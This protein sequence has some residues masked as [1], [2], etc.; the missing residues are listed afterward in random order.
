MWN[1]AKYA[2]YNDAI[3]IAS[4]TNHAIGREIQWPS[5]EKLPFWL[6]INLNCKV[7]LRLLM[8]HLSQ[9]GNHGIMN[10]IKLV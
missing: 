1:W 5:R 3:F 4:C 9:F 8:G 10:P 6:A 2:I 7:A